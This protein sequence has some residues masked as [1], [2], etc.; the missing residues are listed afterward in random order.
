MSAI[1]RRAKLVA[2]AAAALV[3]ATLV[4][5]QAGTFVATAPAQT[6]G[7]SPFA[8]CTTPPGPGSGIK[9]CE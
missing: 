2:G 4:P 9:G 8:S 1:G 3:V 6:S 5:A 7:G